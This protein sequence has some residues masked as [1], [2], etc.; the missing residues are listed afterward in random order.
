MRDEQDPKRIWKEE[1]A[2]IPVIDAREFG[3]KVRQME[4]ST[5]REILASAAA[6]LGVSAIAVWRLRLVESPPLQAAFAAVVAW[7][8]WSLWRFRGRIRRAGEIA[9]LPGVEHYRRALEQRRDHVRHALAWQGPVAVALVLLV[10]ALLGKV[11]GV[12]ELL[13]KA[14]PF[15]I[16]VLVWFG[17]AWV[18]RR[19]RLRQL[20]REISTLDRLDPRMPA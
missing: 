10:A 5:R 18:Q 7:A 12:P 1:G 20:D 2:E 6:A 14:A 19:S 4:S 15:L 3:K 11:G 9:P 8:A 17:S 16:L 13:A